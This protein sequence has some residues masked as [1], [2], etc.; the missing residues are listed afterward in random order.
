MTLGRRISILFFFGIFAAGSTA[1]GYY[2]YYVYSPPLQA[3][4]RFMRAMEQRDT[5][6]LRQAIVMGV[7]LDSSTLRE[8]GPDDLKMLLDE[9][10]ERGRILDQR[11]REGKTRDFDYLVYRE[12]DGQVYAMVVTRIGEAYRVVIPEKRM[13]ERR[14][15]LWEYAWT[16]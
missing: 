10:F 14:R 3:A 16:N 4:E 6:E 2:Y 1:L 13:S 15:Y 7:G 12:P 9:S 5:E 8:P 11:K